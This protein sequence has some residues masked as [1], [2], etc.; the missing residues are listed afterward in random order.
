ML[1]NFT[2]Y[3]MTPIFLSGMLQNFTDLCKKLVFLP[4]RCETYRLRNDACFEGSEWTKQGSR[5]NRKYS[6]TKSGY[7]NVLAFR[8]MH[9]LNF[10]GLHVL[11]FRG[12]HFLAF[13]GLHVFTFRRLLILNFRG[14]HVLAF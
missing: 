9:A 10:R 14:L 6:R 7:D 8:G 11:A 13:G 2:D 3:P 5:A 1:R 4:K 12:L